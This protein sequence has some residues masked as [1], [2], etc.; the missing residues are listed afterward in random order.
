MTA[1]AGALI[2]ADA[3]DVTPSDT[4]IVKAFGFY[5]GVTGDVTVRPAAQE[6]KASP[7]DVTYTNV[8]PGLII[9]LQV[10]RF[11]AATTAT[12]IVAFGPT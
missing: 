10:S 5:V 4:V 7:V 6:G 11:M 12:D 1:T 8:P 3:F 9:P 2:A